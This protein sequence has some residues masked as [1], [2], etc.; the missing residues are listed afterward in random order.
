MPDFKP[1]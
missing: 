1:W